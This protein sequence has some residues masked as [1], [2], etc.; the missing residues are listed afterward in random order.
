MLSSDSWFSLAL[1]LSLDHIHNCPWLPNILDTLVVFACV[2]NINGKDLNTSAIS[3]GK[4]HS[5]D[6]STE[7]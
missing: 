4:H 2:I 3:R 5:L 1:I 6:F 7:I